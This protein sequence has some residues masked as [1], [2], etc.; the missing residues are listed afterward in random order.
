MAD[1]FQTERQP[2]IVLG[3]SGFV[4]RRV[5]AAL[6]DSTQWRAVPVSRR[7]SAPD[8][9]AADATDAAAMRALLARFPDAP[10]V[11]CIAGGG[12][13]AATEALCSAGPARRIVH[14]SSM[15]VYGAA[16]G[17]VTE[18]Q[19]PVAPVSGYGQAKLDCEA[20]L[21]R[22]D[23]PVVVLRP[24]CVFGPGSPQWAIRIAR[25][26]RSGRLGDLGP[27]GD[28]GCNLV[29]TDDLVCAILRALEAPAGTFNLSSP[30]I[31]TWNEFLV[32]FGIALGAT[33]VRRIAARRLT[34]ETKLLAPACRIL[35]RGLDHPLTEAITPSLAALFAQDIR[36]DSSAASRVLDLQATPVERMIEITARWLDGQSASQPEMTHA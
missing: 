33:P 5:V 22:H 2:V 6:R 24:S 26:L 11:N 25:L 21:A 34:I 3:A 27:A 13:Q 36:L 35:S 23:G 4:G 10:V 31:P 16:T 8:G 19:R 7:Q 15:A 30:E 18:A 29:F 17:V 14:L 9:V 1:E 28:G 12:M 32:R 20:R